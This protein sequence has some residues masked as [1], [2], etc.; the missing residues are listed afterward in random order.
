MAANQSKINVCGGVCRIVIQIDFMRLWALPSPSTEAQTDLV[1]ASVQGGA[2]NWSGDEAS[3]HW[4]PLKVGG[5]HSLWRAER[6][7]RNSSHAGPPGLQPPR[8]PTWLH[9]ARAH[10]VFVQLLT[11]ES[12]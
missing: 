8:Q 4:C 1:F 7:G 9:E 2:L 12:V 10:G 11:G 5:T 3:E 6:H